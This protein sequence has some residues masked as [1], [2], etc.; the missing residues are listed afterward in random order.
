MARLYPLYSPI[1]AL[2]LLVHG[3]SQFHRTNGHLKASRRDKRENQKRILNE[4]VGG[5]RW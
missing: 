1:I 4:E 2:I 3:A 5:E